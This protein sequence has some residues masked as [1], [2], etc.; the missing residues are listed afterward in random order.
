MKILASSDVIVLTEPKGGRQLLYP[1]DAKIESY[2]QDLWD[3]S[4]TNRLQ[5]ATETIHGMPHAVFVKPI[6]RISGASGPWITSDGITLTAHSQDLNRWPF[7]VLEGAALYEALGGVPRVSAGV[8]DISSGRLSGPAVPAEFARTGD[9][10]RIS[11]DARALSNE[12][13]NEIGIRLTFDRFFVPSKLGMNADTR[14]LVVM[15]PTRHE[16]RREPE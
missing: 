1:M 5:L 4:A 3:W 13:T 8:V 7:I 14:E 16:L 2:W 11:I 6:V 10:Y 9:T 12:N 15:E